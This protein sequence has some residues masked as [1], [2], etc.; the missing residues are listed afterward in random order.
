MHLYFRSASVEKE[1]LFLSFQTPQTV[2]CGIE[3]FSC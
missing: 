2:Q 1:M 3:G